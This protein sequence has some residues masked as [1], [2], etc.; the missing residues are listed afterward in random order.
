MVLMCIVKSFMGGHDRIAR[1]GPSACNLVQN[2]NLKSR[3]PTLWT[4]SHPGNSFRFGP[5]WSM[6]VWE[7]GRG[8]ITP[9]SHGRQRTA[10]VFV[11]ECGEESC[12]EP[13]L[14]DHLLLVGFLSRILPLPHPQREAI[15]MR[16]N[17]GLST[18]LGRTR[19]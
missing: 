17:S 8:S 9:S 18:R 5:L 11:L 12:L 10:L 19:E 1:G 2:L 3:N 14:F 7:V 4:L 6:G 13:I 16:H 15:S